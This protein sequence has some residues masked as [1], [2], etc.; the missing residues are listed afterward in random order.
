MNVFLFL[1]GRVRR[2]VDREAEGVRLS[3][4]IFGCSR[5]FYTTDGMR[6]SNLTT[7]CVQILFESDSALYGKMYIHLSLIKHGGNL[8]GR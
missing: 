6:K 3:K 8:K 1:R 4:G 5:S 2:V 7:S